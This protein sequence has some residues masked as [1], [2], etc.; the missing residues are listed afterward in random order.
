MNRY[1]PSL[2]STSLVDRF[3]FRVH[4]TA[5]IEEVGLDGLHQHDDAGFVLKELMFAV[6]GR[7][8]LIV[9]R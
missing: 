6:K 1:D 4:S 7:T 8:K 5:T 3:Q 9:Y 2:L